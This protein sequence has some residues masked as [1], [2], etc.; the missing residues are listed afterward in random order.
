MSAFSQ[1]NY[2]VN[3]FGCSIYRAVLFIHLFHFPKLLCGQVEAAP[4][5]QDADE[6]VVR[7][8]VGGDVSLR[9]R[10]LHL[11]EE[12]KRSLARALAAPSLTMPRHDVVVW[13]DSVAKQ[14]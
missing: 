14:T 2:R 12:G 9:G 6:G 4:E 13:H 5:G 1:L 3:L 11:L 10:R 8:L 7:E